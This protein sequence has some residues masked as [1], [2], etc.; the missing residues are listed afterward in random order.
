MQ[1]VSTKYQLYQSRVNQENVNWSKYSSRRTIM[2][3]LITQAK[4]KM[5]RQMGK[6]GI[7]ELSNC[8][9]SLS[10]VDKELK[11]LISEP[12]NQGQSAKAEG[13]KVLSDRSW[14]PRGDT[15]IIRDTVWG[16]QCGEEVPWLLPS[17]NLPF[18]SRAFQWLKPDGGLDSTTLSEQPLRNTRE[19]QEKKNTRGANR[20]IHHHNVKILYRFESN[21]HKNN[22]NQSRHWAWRLESNCGSKVEKLLGKLQYSSLAEKAVYL[23]GRSNEA[24]KVRDWKSLNFNSSRL[25]FCSEV[26]RKWNGSRQRVIWS[27]PHVRNITLIE[28]WW[29]DW[30][31][32]T[33]PGALIKGRAR[34]IPS[35]P[36]QTGRSL[37]KHSVFWEMVHSFH[38]GFQWSPWPLIPL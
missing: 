26:N 10:Y 37:Y 36:G 22:E 16:R 2:K 32:T 25:D 38:M 33:R 17:F 13:S 14:S 8:R 27:K 18:P 29:V 7:Q 35:A 5:E 1:Q 34:G 11:C 24:T 9:K 12:W 23:G 28:I 4:K 15:V 20:Q 21:I 3:A 6:W 31:A 19:G 30:R